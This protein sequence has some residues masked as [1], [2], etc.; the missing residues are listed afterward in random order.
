MSKH[1]M[2][3]VPTA[4]LNFQLSNHDNLVFTFTHFDPF[5][6]IEQIEEIEPEEGPLFEVD[7]D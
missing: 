4:A 2:S 1:P 7:S 3:P 6:N 5:H